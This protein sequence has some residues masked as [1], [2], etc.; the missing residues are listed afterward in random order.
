[1]KIKNLKMYKG[2]LIV[3]DMVNG[4]AKKGDLADPKI[5]DVVPRQIELIKEAKA[6]GYLI[7]FIKDTHKEDSVE[8][9][10]FNGSKHCVENSGEE[11]VID[12]LKEYEDLEDTISILKNST[13][14]M[15]AP[16]FR[17][18]ISEATNIERVDVVG[19]CT[20]I[21][22]ANGT[23]GLANYFDQWN[24]DV[25]IRVHEDAIAT[26]LEGDRQNYVDAAKLL[27]AQQGIKLVKKR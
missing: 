27:M 1:M 6:N 15:E 26:F 4:F 16:E 23:I 20:D 9:K 13:S 17:E 2:M 7:V 24:R 18:L 12:E 8:H 19:C 11:L 10:R 22:V 21:C 3:V 25:E 14:Y 5:G